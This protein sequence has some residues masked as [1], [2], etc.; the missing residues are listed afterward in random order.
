VNYK[1]VR[2]FYTLKSAKAFADVARRLSLTPEQL[3]FLERQKEVNE[4]LTKV[5]KEM[6]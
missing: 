1:P 4:R 2:E 5:R 3:D 6:V